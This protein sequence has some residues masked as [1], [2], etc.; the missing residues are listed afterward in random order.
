LMKN[1]RKVMALC[2]RKW[3]EK[4]NDILYLNC[5]MR[6]TMILVRYWITGSLVEPLGYWSNHITKLDNTK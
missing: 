3:K 2:A 1:V 4:T 5:W 6:A